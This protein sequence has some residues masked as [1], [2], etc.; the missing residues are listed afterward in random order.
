M[1]VGIVEIIRIDL[2]GSIAVNIMMITT[3]VD[4]SG[5]FT[6]DLPE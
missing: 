6:H 4:R 3:V 5:V 2:A 1:M